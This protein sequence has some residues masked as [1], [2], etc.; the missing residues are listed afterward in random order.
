MKSRIIVAGLA[1]G[2]AIFLWGFVAHMFLPLGQAGMRALPYQD[3]VLP[4]L[5]ASVKEPGLYIF[6]WPES[7][8]GTPMPVNQQAQEA[9][10]ELYKTSPHGLLL[11][12]P[13]PAA[14]M[15]GGQLL[16]EF[17]TNY[18]SALIAAFLVAL[19]VNSLR[20]YFTRV[21]FVTMIGLSAAIAVNVPYWNW[22]EFPTAFILAEIVEHVVGFAVAGLVIAAIIKPA[23]SPQLATPGKVIEKASLRT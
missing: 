18:A 5:S 20:S 21:L 22:Y 23:P 19:V 1:G 11:F 6:P 2:V 4:A 15:T 7:S 3:K 12:H 13:P 9:A 14:M 10:A 17:A 8:P 16:T